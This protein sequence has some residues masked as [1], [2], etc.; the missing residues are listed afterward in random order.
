MIEWMNAADKADATTT[1]DD[2]STRRWT[3][4]RTRTRRDERYVQLV[5]ADPTTK[6]KMTVSLGWMTEATYRRAREGLNAW[7]TRLLGTPDH[8]TCLTNDE[9]RASLLEDTGLVAKAMADAMARAEVTRTAPVYDAAT[10]TLATFV[11]EIWLPVYREEQTKDNYDRDVRSFWKFMRPVLGPVRLADI[12]GKVWRRYLTKK[13]EWR[14]A[15]TRARARAFLMRALHHAVDVGYLDD[16]P[17][18]QVRI[19][20][21]NHKADGAPP[22]SR[23]DRTFTEQ[24]ALSVINAGRDARSRAMFAMALGVALRPTEVLRLRWENLIAG[25]GP[26]R[27]EGTKN[28]NAVAEIHI[29]VLARYC[30]DEWWTEQRHPETGWVFPGRNGQPAASWRKRFRAAVKRAGIV[31]GNRKLTPYS[32]R[33]T[34]ATLLYF[35][36][37][38]LEAIRQLLR[39][40]E[41]SR[42]LETVYIRRSTSE[43]GRRLQPVNPFDQADVVTHLSPPPKRAERTRRSPGQTT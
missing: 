29:P 35:K 17:T 16:V 43:S 9:V 11:D 22:T 2:P 19:R 8:R 30:L 1:T 3:L 42:I 23:Q 10:L 36:N 5:Y 20:R 24:E 4:Q 31:V 33:H 15:S 28:A 13:T 21:G 27:V 38:D 41:R 18:I 39:H 12:D 34:F 6:K 14:A 32:F 7:G 37:G 26:N 40:H 25:D